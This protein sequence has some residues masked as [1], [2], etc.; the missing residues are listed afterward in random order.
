MYQQ[1]ICESGRP[2]FYDL[3]LFQC[4]F[5]EQPVPDQFEFSDGEDVCFANVSV[6]TR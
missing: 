2:W 6:I 3:T 5:G 4:S 1:H